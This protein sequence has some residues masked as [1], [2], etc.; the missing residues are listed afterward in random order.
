MSRNHKQKNAAEPENILT[1]I[2]IFILHFVPLK[3]MICDQTPENHFPECF[4]S[5]RH[6]AEWQFGRKSFSQIAVLPNS[7]SHKFD[8]PRFFLYD[9]FSRMRHFPE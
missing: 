4:S 9:L 3:H 6:L 2:I 5:E 8:F 1:I 7:R